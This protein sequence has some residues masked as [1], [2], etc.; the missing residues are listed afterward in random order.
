[1]DSTYEEVRPR[2]KSMF[3]D[4]DQVRLSMLQNWI[5]GS[6]GVHGKS[7]HGNRA[8]VLEICQRAAA[9]AENR[10]TGPWATFMGR[11]IQ[12][13]PRH[14]GSD[15]RSTWACLSSKPGPDLTNA[16][17]RLDRER[18]DRRSALDRLRQAR[19]SRKAP[20]TAKIWR[21]HHHLI[22][23]PRA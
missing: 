2:P 6:H 4:R 11:T 5:P 12:R 21:Y 7:S 8:T 10:N 13:Y 15:A 1:V 19:H 17:Q 20:I 18:L 9:L 3:G 23:L 22:G 16:P 14:A